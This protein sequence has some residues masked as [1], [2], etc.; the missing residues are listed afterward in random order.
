MARRRRRRRRGEA[1]ARRRRGGGAAAAHDRRRP[2]REPAL[3]RHEIGPLVPPR[4]ADLAARR[5]PQPR[6]EC[7]P[8]EGRAVCGRPRR[9]LVGE[10]RAG[11]TDAAGT[12]LD[13]RG[14]EAQGVRG[15]ATATL[16]EGRP[17]PSAGTCRRRPAADIVPAD[18][19]LTAG[20]TTAAGGAGG[21]H[22][23]PA[24]CRSAP[25]GREGATR[26]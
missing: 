21:Q 5:A 3:A 4:P 19:T 17:G 2:H 25:R 11:A 23:S 15:G 20:G 6:R 18:D 9:L 13:A 10:R 14:L 24:A 22:D 8:H 26:R 12:P 16:T 7:G 1:A